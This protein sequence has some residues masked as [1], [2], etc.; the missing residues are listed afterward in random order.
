MHLPAD[1]ARCLS[2]NCP[3]QTNC[4]RQ[5]PPPEGAHRRQVYAAF[6]PDPSGYCGD[7][8]PMPPRE[9]SHVVAT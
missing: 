9:E 7:Y 6:A 4:A 5:Q 2:D 3:K 8:I 1:I